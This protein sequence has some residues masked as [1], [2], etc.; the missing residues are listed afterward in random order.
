MSFPKSLY[1]DVFK[2]VPK[3][4]FLTGKSMEGTKPDPQNIVTNQK[5]PVKGTAGT[6]T[7]LNKK[8]PMETV[9]QFIKRHEKEELKILSKTLKNK[10]A[11]VKALNNANKKSKTLFESEVSSRLKQKAMDQIEMTNVNVSA[12]FRGTPQQIADRM[13]RSDMF[14]K[15]VE[16][17]YG[18]SIDPNTGKLIELD[19]LKSRESKPGFLDTVTEGMGEY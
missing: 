8:K 5:P 1:G 16:R 3:K 10:S 9:S 17:L 18:I 14:R 19:K 11:A 15:G 13:K 6:G 2:N 12:F 4:D 7:S